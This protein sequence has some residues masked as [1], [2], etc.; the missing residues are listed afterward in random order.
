LYTFLKHIEGRLTQVP[1]YVLFAIFCGVLLLFYWPVRNY[2]LIDD[3]ISGLWEVRNMPWTDFVHSFG[4]GS[5]YQFHYLSLVLFEH[6]F[7]IQSHYYFLVFLLLHAVIACYFV[8]I[9]KLL[10]RRVQVQFPVLFAILLGLFFVSSPHLFETMA[11]A[12]PSH[13]VITLW[14]YL[15]LFHQFLKALNKNPWNKTLFFVVFFITVFT[16]EMSVLFLPSFL[17]AGILLRQDETIIS[18]VKRMWIVYLPM[19]LILIA[20]YTL[21]YFQQRT[22]IPH[23]IPAAFIGQSW[24][25]Y[26]K[27]LIVYLSRIWAYTHS[28][29]LPAREAYYSFVSAFNA[30]LILFLLLVVSVGFLREKKLALF[31][32]FNGVLFLLPYLFRSFSIL[33]EYEN[34]RYTYFA[35]VFIMA[36]LLV[37]VWN[38]KAIVGI[39]LFLV[40]FVLNAITT[41]KGVQAKVINGELHEQYVSELNK[42][43]ANKYYLL[44]VPSFCQGHFVFRADNRVGIAA[45]MHGKKEKPEQFKEVMYYYAQSASDSF[46]VEVV[47]D[48]TLFI[49][50]ETPGIW[51]MEEDRG[52]LDYE[53]EDYM[54][55]T[56]KWASYTL[57]LKQHSV[58]K[59]AVILLYSK[60]KMKR[61]NL[62]TQ[63]QNKLEEP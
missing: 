42:F 11:W 18:H 37:I 56:G 19:L 62:L 12:G 59:K 34:A 58:L 8:L 52:A 29:S 44:N 14:L 20:A 51:L 30:W 40:L 32:F 10:F 49:Q 24:S 33:N 41:L 5:L 28:F 13:Y 17:L 53:T 46:S 57:I 31:L 4:Y 54:V 39:L 7:G 36:A 38:K 45:Q 21:F 23:G 48:S 25:V 27:H 63:P 26:S 15:V 9:S 43:Q 35:F 1:Q 6:L 3:G 22:I 61:I 55:V 47:N 16:F 2:L 50:P 60:G